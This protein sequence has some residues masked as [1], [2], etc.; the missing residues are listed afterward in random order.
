MRARLF[1]WAFEKVLKMIPIDIALP[2]REI[3]I[4]FILGAKPRSINTK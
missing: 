2:W 1:R 3:K 4:V